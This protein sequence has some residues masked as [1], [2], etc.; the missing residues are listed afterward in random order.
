MSKSDLHQLEDV[1][2]AVGER[3]PVRLAPSRRRH[4]GT[5]PRSRTARCSRA[6]PRRA[7]ARRSGTG[8]WRC[9]RRTGRSRHRCHGGHH[10]SLFQAAAGVDGKRDAGDVAGFVGGQEQHRV[11]DVHR[12]RPTGSAAC[13]R[14][15]RSGRGRRARDSPDRAGTSDR[16]SR[17]SAT[18][19][20]RASG[21]T[22]LTRMMCWPSS[23]AKVRIK[24]TT[25]CL[26]AT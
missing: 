14:S 10:G 4:A 3:L 13:G 22:E 2:S 25:P 23:T 12:R 15:G 20:S 18:V 9:R 24:P 26:A 21:C 11:A 5:A 17:S 16:S 7:G 8:R 19:C 1:A 6:A